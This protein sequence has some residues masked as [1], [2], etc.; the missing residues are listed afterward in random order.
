MDNEMLKT[1]DIRNGFPVLDPHK[2][3]KILLLSDDLRMTSG[4]GVMSK[5]LVKGTIHRYNWDQVGAAIKHPDKGKIFDLSQ[6][7]GKR[8]K[9]ETP[10]LKVYPSD[11]YGNPDLIRHII[12]EE[13]F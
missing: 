3:K 8:I 12:K 4:I 1:G 7:M 9:V 6:E 13:D 11:G 2:R 10:Y 5:E